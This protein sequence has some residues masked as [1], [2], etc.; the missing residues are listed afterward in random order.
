[1]RE[2]RRRRRGSVVDAGCLDQLLRGDA[3]VT[4][5]YAR[6]IEQVSQLIVE[7]VFSVEE[8]RLCNPLDLDKTLLDVLRAAGRRAMGDLFATL[9]LGVEADAEAG[10]ARLSV[11]RRQAITVDTVFGSVAVESPYLWRPGGGARPVQDVLGLR[12]RRRSVAVERALT[13]FG[14]EDSFDHAAKRFAEHY[15]WEIGRTSVLRVVEERAK[16][17]ETYVAERLAR[18]AA[19]FDQPVGVRPGV[20]EI[21]VELDGCEIRTGTL[22]PANTDEKTPIRQAPKRKRVEE[23]RD[24]RVGL[25]RRLDE[26]ERTYVARMDSY[27]AVV[28]QLFQAAVGRGL[29]TRTTTVAVGDGGNGLRE[30]LAAQLPNLRFIYDQP[31][32]REHLG[33]TAEAMG[34]SGDDRATWI[35]CMVA[36]ADA[37]R[38]DQVL[39]EL[40]A[41]R[42]RGK[43]RVGQLH[44]HLSRL[45]DAVH[46]S[47]YRARGWPIG[48]GEVESAHRYVPQKRL[49]LPGATWSPSTINPMLALRVVRANGWWDDF[50]QRRRQSAAA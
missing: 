27:P 36:T 42:G 18:E 32:L 49:K 1:V 12:H 44:K 50:W 26:T 2:K 35:E 39:D 37:G 3:A 9:A 34:L 45:A 21:L 31:H 22:V 15:G 11:Q 4:E 7:G 29:S 40:A 25:T 38:S 13:D 47:D 48:S 28:S 14:A 24:V 10:D 19:C 16:E 6:V 41:H 5:R 33:D 46:Y 20:D 8:E 30:E 23:W 43:K 17:V